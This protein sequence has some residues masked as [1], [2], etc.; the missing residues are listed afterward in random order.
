MSKLWRL[1]ASATAITSAA[2]FHQPW[3]KLPV[4]GVPR[5]CSVAS[6]RTVPS[7]ARSERY[8]GWRQGPPGRTKTG[9]PPA[10]PSS[11]K[12][13]CKPSGAVI[14]STWPNYRAG[15]QSCGENTPAWEKSTGLGN[16]CRCAAQG[17]PKL[18]GI[19]QTGRDFPKGRDL[20]KGRNAGPAGLPKGR[21]SEPAA[22]LGQA[23][24]NQSLGQ[25]LGVLQGPAYVSPGPADKPDPDGTD[26]VLPALFLYQGVPRR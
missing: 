21:S 26:R 13:I 2:S 22:G 12:L 10:V 7:P 5:A 4:S 8:A 3:E 11:W 1:S 16:P 15:C 24:P 20:S 14:L 6:G 17:F 25:G 23:C 19:S 18:A 9:C